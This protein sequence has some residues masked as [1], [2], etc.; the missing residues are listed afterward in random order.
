MTLDCTDSSIKGYVEYQPIISKS[1]LKS[2]SEIQSGRIYLLGELNKRNSGAGIANILDFSKNEGF[3]N[4]QL[5]CRAYKVGLPL[6]YKIE[7]DKETAGNGDDPLPS[8]VENVKKES[9]NGSQEN[10]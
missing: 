3:S 6:P 10:K 1:C 7:T 9:L 8:A 4:V 2:E 5:F